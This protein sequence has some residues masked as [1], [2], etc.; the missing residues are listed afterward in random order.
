M[1]SNIVLCGFMGCG[2]TT[3]GKLLAEQLS[4]P[5]ADTDDS[6]RNI[7]HRSIHDMLENGQLSLVRAYE[8]EAV[9]MLAQEKN[10]VIATGA[11]VCA[12]EE[13][14]R[15]LHE[16]GWLVYLRRDFALVYPVISR[17]PIRVMAYRK[18]YAEMKA[19]LDSRDALYRRYADLVIDNNGNPADCAGAIA[20]FFRS[21]TA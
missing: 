21:G 4:M 2:K 6:V 10:T 20:A 12:V 11:G 18:S 3:V 9:R 1:K 15:I 8:S 7:A 16:S 19:L 14:A 5:F 13:N 17:D